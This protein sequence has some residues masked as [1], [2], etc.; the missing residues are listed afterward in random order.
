MNYTEE[1]DASKKYKEIYAKGI[2]DIILSRQK[3][4]TDR[5]RE[6]SKNILSDAERCRDD[7]KRMLGW[8]LVDHAVEGLPEV[9]SEKLFEGDEYSIFRMSFCV[10]EGLVLSGLYFENHGDGKRPLVI[11]Q[12]GGSGTPELISGIYENNTH[13]YNGMLERVLKYGVDVFAPQLLLWENTYDVPFARRDIDA[14]LKRVGSSITA[15]EI[16]GVMRILDYFEAKDNITDFGM[17][18]LSYGGFYTLYTAAIDT[19]ISSSVSCAFFNKRDE[20]PWLLPVIK[21]KFSSPAPTLF[22]KTTVPQL[23]QPQQ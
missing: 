16:Y 2:E 14:R 6:Y 19:R 9:S 8:P 1:R 5:R 3:E 21:F 23:M 10:L 17:V 13:N 12:H 7:F 4:A 22:C 15:V 20:I 18:G 11:V